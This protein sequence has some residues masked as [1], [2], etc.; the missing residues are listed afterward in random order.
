MKKLL[1]VLAIS[2]F[3]ACGSGSSSTT[4][5][6]STT[7][8]TDTVKTDTTKVMTMDSTKKMTDSTKK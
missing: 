6:D 1:A 4:T 5:T 8:K 7:V 3:A 2:T